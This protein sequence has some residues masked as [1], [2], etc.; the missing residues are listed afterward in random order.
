MNRKMELDLSREMC[1]ACDGPIAKNLRTE[2]EWCINP[3][4]LICNVILSIPY[5]EEKE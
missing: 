2:K 4:C 1:H 3:A 5:K